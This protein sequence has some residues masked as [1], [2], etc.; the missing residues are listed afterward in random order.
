M[1]ELPPEKSESPREIN[2]DADTR[3][4]A[5]ELERLKDARVGADRWNPGCYAVY[6]FDSEG[7]EIRSAGRFPSVRAASDAV[8]FLQV[9]SILEAIG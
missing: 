6:F 7:E 2:W 3:I 9:E 4:G 1:R 8:R 5:A